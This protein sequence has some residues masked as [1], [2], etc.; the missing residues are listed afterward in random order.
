M[1]ELFIS[2]TE[3]E[4]ANLPMPEFGER[5]IR[6]VT[7]LSRLVED[8][9]VDHGSREDCLSRG[10]PLYP[11]RYGG[12]FVS[13]VAPD[14]P[15]PTSAV[16]HPSH[17]TTGGI[18]CIDAIRAQLTDEGFAAYCQGNTAKYLWRHKHK[19]GLEDL[20]KAKVYLEWLIETAAKLEVE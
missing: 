11:S 9:K 15:K 17:Y 13:P 1:S 18:E 7:R 4:L 12:T 20:N 8:S 16:N 19:G 5:I 6:E 10:A 3:D 14:Q 2:L